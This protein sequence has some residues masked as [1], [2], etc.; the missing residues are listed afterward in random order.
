M[1]EESLTQ[2]LEASAS[3]VSRAASRLARGVTTGGAH[4][5]V[6]GGN[7]K[8]KEVPAEN[9][10]TRHPL[11]TEPPLQ[12]G[13]TLPEALSRMIHRVEEG[14]WCG[15][16]HPLETAA[17]VNY[18]GS[19][20]EPL[21]PRSDILS[22]PPSAVDPCTSDL[23]TGQ[24]VDT[25]MKSSR[26]G[27]DMWSCPPRWSLMCCSIYTGVLLRHIFHSM[28]TGKENLLLALYV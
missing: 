27:G 28:G 19:D 25:D 9:R 17:Q 6:A 18:V 12:L 3:V 26:T 1:N 24:Q 21:V 8:R 15:E 16:Q 2:C 11:V 5:T 23:T 13:G 20:M 7:K 14:V 4:P 22:S 10:I